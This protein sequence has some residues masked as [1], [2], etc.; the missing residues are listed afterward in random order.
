MGRRLADSSCRGQYLL[1]PV[2]RLYA[3]GNMKAMNI[4]MG[5]AMIAGRLLLHIVYSHAK[6]RLGA[7][8]H[9]LGYITPFNDTKY[10]GDI[11]D[12]VPGQYTLAAKVS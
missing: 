10:P 6:R 2:L 5:A 4:G 9:A 3:Y 7:Q 12:D 1:I 8:G 11:V